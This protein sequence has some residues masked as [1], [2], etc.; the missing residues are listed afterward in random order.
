MKRQKAVKEAFQHSWK[1]Y[2]KHAWLHDELSP[3]TATHR[4]AF[5]GWAATLVDSLD[6]LVIMGMDNEFEEAL[7]AL[8]RID[9]TTTEENQ[10]NIFET[11]IR[12]IGGFLGAYDLT[13]GQY[14][15]L[16]RKATEVADM[17]Y[18]AFD[19]SNGM[20]QCRWQWTR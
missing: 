8:D 5:G 3:I 16:L 10:I 13:N 11:T 14:P 17:L 6:T 4:D 7:A 19:T 20:P 2:R 12:Y 15:I 1:G 9:F 18:D